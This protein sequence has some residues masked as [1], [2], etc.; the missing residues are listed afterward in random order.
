MLEPRRCVTT[1][2]CS[3]LAIGVLTNFSEFYIRNN[4]MQKS[5][6]GSNEMVK[7]DDEYSSAYKQLT[8]IFNHDRIT[9]RA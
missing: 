3:E 6:Q 8:S 5:M 1:D 4:D 2:T 7:I 9:D